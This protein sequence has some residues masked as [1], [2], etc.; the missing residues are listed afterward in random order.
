MN[1]KHECQTKKIWINTLDIGEN[2][3]LI[4]KFIKFS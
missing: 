2:W 1:K 3:R 4:K